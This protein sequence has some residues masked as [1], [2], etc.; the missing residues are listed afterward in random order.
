MNKEEREKFIRCLE[1]CMG[2]TKTLQKGKEETVDNRGAVLQKREPA[3]DG[4]LLDIWKNRNGS[5]RV[6]IPYTDLAG[7]EFPFNNPEDY[8][9]ALKKFDEKIKESLLPTLDT[10]HRR[11]WERCALQCR[12]IK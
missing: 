10:Y 1:K 7:S 6:G 3:A 9:S 4:V 2:L 12:G 8:S 11:K 5:Y